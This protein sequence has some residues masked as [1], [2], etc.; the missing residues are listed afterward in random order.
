MT[1]LSEVQQAFLFH[2]DDLYDFVTDTFDEHCGSKDLALAYV[3]TLRNI[4][5]KCDAEDIR[6]A[7]NENFNPGPFILVGVPIFLDEAQYSLMPALG[8]WGRG[9]ETA[10][11]GLVSSAYS[12]DDIPNHAAGF[13][14]QLEKAPAKLPFEITW[15]YTQM[16]GKFIPPS[17]V[18]GYAKELSPLI[19][20]TYLEY[21]SLGFGAGVLAE[22]ANSLDKEK[23][24][25]EP[26]LKKMWKYY[27]DQVE[28]ALVNE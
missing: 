3:K 1:F 9:N 16:I 4:E 24:K 21:L 27:L 8:R 28:E 15:D 10:T 23:S 25:I 13:R 5:V 12:E 14:R 22:G 6:T 2:V 19:I 26:F 7:T 18:K 17:A 20:G 11:L